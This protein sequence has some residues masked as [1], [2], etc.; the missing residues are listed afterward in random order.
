MNPDQ[1]LPHIVTVKSSAGA[2]KTYSLALRYL[3]LLALGEAGPEPA[4][5]NRICNIVAITFTNKAASE[6]RSRIIDWMKRVIL[7]LPFG[8]SSLKPTDAVLA[9]ASGPC[10]R[11]D[12]IRTVEADFEN[13][14]RNFY[15]FKV[16]TIDSFVN[17]T[18]KASAFKL[19]LPPDFEIS[20]ESAL[21]VDA[22]LQECL[23]EILE[24]RDV[25]RQFD[26]FLRAYIE[27]EGDNAA[28]VPKRFLTDTVYRFWKEEAKENK[29]FLPGPAP[30][31][32]EDIRKKI[33]AK[34]AALIDDIIEAEGVKI[35]KGFLGSLEGLAALGR[36][37]FKGS[38]YFRRPTISESLNK[39]SAP[40][41]DAAELTW[42][43]IRS[44]LALYVEALAE[45]KFSSYLEIYGLFKN[46]LRSEVTSRH[47]IILIEELN[48]L[49][50]DV[51]A[52]EDFIPEIYYALAERYSHFLIDEFQDTNLLQW[53]NIGVLADEALSR[54]G[55]LFLVGDKKQAIYRWRGGRAELVDEIA[56]C[57][58]AY[59]TLP[60]CLDINY[61]SGEHVVSFNN[62][63][64]GP[65][66]I[67][68]L[69]R[70]MAGGDIPGLWTRI[71]ETYAGSAQQCVERKKGEGYVSVEKLI[72]EGEDGEDGGKFSQEEREALTLD[73]VESLVR[74]IRARRVYRDRDIAV[75]VR[76]REE[77]ESVVKR[78][79]EAGIAVDSEFTVN[80]RNNPLM[81]EMIGFLQ[82][83]SAPHDDA[84]LAGFLTGAI[85]AEV[86][87]AGRKEIIN[88]I[89]TER[90]KPHRE[91]LYKAFRSSHTGL[92]EE[93]FADFFKSAGYLPLYELFVLI[94]KRW[95]I[96]DRFPEHAPYFLHVCEM[97][98]KREGMGS[99]NLTGFLDF[100]GE[101]AGDGFDGP[102]TDDA[103]FL[104]KTAEGAD[105]VKVL[106]VHKAKGLQF[107]VVILPFLKLADFA[108]SDRRD[109][110]KFFVSVDEG[111]KLLNIKKDYLD[112]STALRDVYLEN[113]TEYLV[114][115]I[116]NI[117]V[118]CTRAG[119]EL[120]IFLTD[121]RRQKNYLIDYLYGIPAFQG[122]ISA[123]VM[124]TGRKTE[125]I[126]E[127]RIPPAPETPP[128]G[129]SLRFDAA[130]KDLRWMAKVHG[131][132]E[133]PESCSKEQIH[134][135][136]RGDAIHYILS[137][138]EFLPED[139]EAFL[140]ESVPRAAAR[141]GLRTEE[142]E[143]K[144]IM[145]RFLSQASFGRFFLPGEGAVVYRER[146]LTDSRGDAYKPDRIIVRNDSIDVIDFKTGETRSPDH[147][148]QI[149]NYGRLL[150][151]IHEG[152]AVRKH[153]VYMDENRLETL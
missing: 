65:E 15:D 139:Y 91:P 127:D 101:G 49:L 135:K 93:Y 69:L 39:G 111:L 28:W 97:I 75:L 71:A 10:A 133:P 120:Y 44:L 113:E 70:S 26:S 149:T 37:E 153:L 61:R 122:F 35:H 29:E 63:L 25:R 86:S 78:L 58:P 77:A 16:S 13:L 41:S 46:R 73:R 30:S 146:E 151:A 19:G 31:Y 109:K 94:L 34:T 60:M 52:G 145:V 55:T 27:L 107:P 102:R 82:F 148:E 137:L 76:R 105:A 110:G 54:G 18:L 6:M 136:K 129:D 74:E 106:T 23:Q 38:A 3:Q 142:A 147:V 88:W 22:V 81:K 92:W 47:R 143:L 116:N 150:E 115:E 40:V 103:P 112:F 80:V 9:G 8:D 32:V 138:I 17:L 125:A 131:K 50:Q 20:T 66:N 24:N 123:G 42:Q 90:L 117:Y 132:F 134:A 72:P 11:E 14:I 99:N 67:Q 43:E 1:E 53:K 95:Q 83:L 96:M 21:H 4:P 33:T 144:A 62:A 51:I 36:S 56:A 114:D 104:L 98:N 48:K 45:S 85:F 89:T 5:R 124:E 7:D 119:K 121:S 108:S 12:L 64:F 59:R 57:Y 68:S 79:L 152:R 87:G 140:A 2:G 128:A 126:R 84:V 118:A 100:W 130:G 141:F